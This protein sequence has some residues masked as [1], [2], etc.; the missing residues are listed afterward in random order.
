MKRLTQWY[1]AALWEF[2]YSIGNRRLASLTLVGLIAAVFSH[3]TTRNA[4]RI[5]RDDLQEIVT[6]SS[7]SA[8]PL[9]Q[10]AAEGDSTAI[11]IIFETV[12]LRDSLSI[13]GAF[14]ASLDFTTF[15]VA[16]S[17]AVL[18]GASLVSSWK[19]HRLLKQRS[20]ETGWAAF[21][22]GAQI[23]GL[24]LS[25]LFVIGVLASSLVVGLVGELVAETTGEIEGSSL[26]P[27]TFDPGLS[28]IVPK[29]ALSIGVFWLFF[30]IG[31]SLREVLNSMIPVI[32]LLIGLWV[33]PITS[34]SDP[35]NPLTALAFDLLDFRGGFSLGIA[36][37]PSATS[38]LISAIVV[39]FSLVSPYFAVGL[40]S[41][42]R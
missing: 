27:S 6:L 34:V 13:P 11:G 5:S 7:E 4:Y 10:A 1:E 18:L 35:R 31:F 30:L 37:E 8:S 24:M 17:V 25:F 22:G 3:L 15:I 40:R 12:R 26:I 14:H 36:I 9:L 29:L 38:W 33:V 41:R 2:L 39:I 32:A 21:V 19:T 42:F 16:P 23:A 28:P 20:T